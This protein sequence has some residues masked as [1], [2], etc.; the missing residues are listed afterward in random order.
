MIIIIGLVVLLIGAK[1]FYNRNV[2]SYEWDE[3]DRQKL[4]N[5]CIDGTAHYGIRF[6]KLTVEYCT[7]ST[8]SIMKN[9]KKAEYLQISTKSM[10]EQERVL[11]PV[12]KDCYNWYQ[13][14]IFENTEL[15]EP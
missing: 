15:G 7:C 13:T 8:D 5:N 1:W 6:P 4:I 12:I 10:M 2:N 3:D 11:M 14:E 9:V